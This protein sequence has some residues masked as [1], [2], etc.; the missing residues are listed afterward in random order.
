[1]KLY[2]VI[3]NIYLFSQK[4]PG[5]NLLLFFPIKSRLIFILILSIFLTFVSTDEENPIKEHKDYG[6][7]DVLDSE[8]ITDHCDNRTKTIQDKIIDYIH[9]N[10][11]H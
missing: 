4:I 11:P 8:E 1:M 2:V 3:A 9:K 5:I 10:S 7:Y 6:S